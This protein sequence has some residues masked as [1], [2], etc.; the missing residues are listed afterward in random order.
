MGCYEANMILM[1]VMRLNK[2]ITTSQQDPIV[3]KANQKETLWISNGFMKQDDQ[4]QWSLPFT[5]KTTAHLVGLFMC[6]CI[7]VIQWYGFKPVITAVD[8]QLTSD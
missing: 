1:T 3:K 2:I 7:K 6:L 8:A 4:S 5:P